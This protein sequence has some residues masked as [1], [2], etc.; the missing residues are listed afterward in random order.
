MKEEDEE[1]ENEKEKKNLMVDRLEESAVVDE[2]VDMHRIHLQL[3]HITRISAAAH[4][5][6]ECV[7]SPHVCS[8]MLTYSD[9]C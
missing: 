5:S 8:H 3:I 2:G 4:A 6:V 9:V 1:R 7:H